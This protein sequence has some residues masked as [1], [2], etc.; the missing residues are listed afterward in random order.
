MSHAAQESLGNQTL[1]YTA[2]EVASIPTGL[3]NNSATTSRALHPSD[4][5]TTDGSRFGHVWKVLRYIVGGS[6]PYAP[7]K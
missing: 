6:G 1:T 3:G 7:P 2:G 4:Q 5:S